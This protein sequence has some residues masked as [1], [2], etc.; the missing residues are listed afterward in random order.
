MSTDRGDEV[1]AQF[2]LMATGCLSTPKLPEVD[3]ID[4]FGG[5]TYHT[6]MWPHEGVDFSG[7]RV[8]VIGTGLVRHP[9]DPVDRRAGSRT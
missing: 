4:T 9:G 3:G 7:R 6:A 5:A 1:S 2:L 8:A